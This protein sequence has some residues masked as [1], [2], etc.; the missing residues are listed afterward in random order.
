[1][2]YMQTTDGFVPVADDGA[3][4]TPVPGVQ[5]P[6]TAKAPVGYWQMPDCVKLK[7]C[8]ICGT[9]LAEV[10]DRL[11]RYCGK[12]PCPSMKG[13]LSWQVALDAELHRVHRLRQAC[14]VQ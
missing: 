7:E 13:A 8:A 3:E 14:Y 9:R 4:L 1:M 2:D 12:A 5:E 10:H 6:A 11:A